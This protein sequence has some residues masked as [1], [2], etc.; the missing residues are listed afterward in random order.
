MIRCYKQED[1]EGFVSIIGKADRMSPSAT[2]DRLE[3]WT[4]LVWEESATVKG[5]V[6]YEKEDDGEFNILTYVDPDSRHR[7]INTLGFRRVQ[8]DEWACMWV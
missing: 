2:Q 7:G 5:V 1:L 3:K 6:C 4:S 8:V